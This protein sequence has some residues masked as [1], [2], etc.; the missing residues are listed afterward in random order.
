MPTDIEIPK[1]APGLQKASL[2]D[3]ADADEDAVQAPV[4]KLSQ[5]ERDAKD[6]QLQRALDVLRDGSVA[7]AVRLQPTAVYAKPT[8]KF[9]PAQAAPKSA[10]PGLNPA[11]R[12][13]AAGP[14]EQVAPSKPA[15]VVNV[16]SQR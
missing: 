9:I 16:P 15:P 13:S 2:T 7:A 14:A 4:E 8:P 3:D 12:S 1:A 10:V 5:A 11:A 6:F